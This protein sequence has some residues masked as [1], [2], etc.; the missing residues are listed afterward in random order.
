MEKGEKG[1]AVK[2]KNKMKL[3]LLFPPSV[4][5]LLFP[6]LYWFVYWE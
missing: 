1:E 6:S 5:S 3:V 4:L 2:S